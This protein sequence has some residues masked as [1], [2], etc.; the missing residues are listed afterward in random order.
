MNPSGT[1]YNQNAYNAQMMQLL[2]QAYRNQNTQQ[3]PQVNLSI[4]APPQQTTPM[5]SNPMYGVSQLGVQNHLPISSSR[6][7]SANEQADIKQAQ[8]EQW[9]PSL[10]RNY[11]SK[12]TDFMANPAKKGFLNG[13]LSAGILGGFGALMGRLFASDSRTLMID[14]T[15]AKIAAEKAARKASH[16]KGALIGL[17]IGAGLG[18]L[19]SISAGLSQAR[20]N[21]TYEELMTRF[22]EGSKMRDIMSDS[23][24]QSS[25]NRAAMRKRR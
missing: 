11:G 23:A 18:L 14:A 20:K 5:L 3:P 16:K 22:P 25:M 17:A 24:L 15:E 12:P 7:L 13:L 8:Q 1:G 6:E 19:S 10:T 4:Q 21:G 9:W 2:Q